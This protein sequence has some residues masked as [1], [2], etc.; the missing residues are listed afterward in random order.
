MCSLSPGET[1]Q[2]F[3]RDDIRQDSGKSGALDTKS[4][5]A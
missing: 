4:P 2:L 1:K 3:D 5:H